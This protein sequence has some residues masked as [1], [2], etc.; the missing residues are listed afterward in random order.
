M[1]R[2]VAVA[3]GLA[4]ASACARA[5]APAQDD[6]TAA[7][8]PGFAGGRPAPDPFDAD[9]GLASRV[10]TLFSLRCAGGPESGCHGDGAGGTTLDLRAPGDVIGV[11]SSERPDLLRVKPFD[12]EHSYLYFKVASDGGIDG[13]PMP[14]DQT[15]DP[16]IP[17]LVEAWI[18]AGAPRP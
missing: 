18:R 12:P 13:S 10:G 5:A 17:A 15:F 7:P 2:A 4:F 16:R 6:T 1:K 8:D 11:A 9:A 3:L 14:L